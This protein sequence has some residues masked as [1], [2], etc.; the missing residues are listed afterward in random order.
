MVIGST[1]YADRSRGP[2]TGASEPPRTTAITG[3]EGS[4]C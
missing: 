2:E 1:P 3:A 4:M